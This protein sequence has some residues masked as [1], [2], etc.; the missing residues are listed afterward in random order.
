MKKIS[1]CLDMYGCP[2]KCKH[3]WLGVTP[4]G[5][6]TF[7]DLKFVANVFRPFTKNLEVFDRYRE[8]DYPNNYKELWDL[9]TELSDSKT[10]HFENISYWRVVRDS[11]YA[12]WLYSIGVR[13]A[14][15][16]VFGDQ[17]TTDDFIGRKGAFKE[18]LQAID[19]LLQSKIAPRVQMF[20]YKSNIP[21]L[22]YVQQLIETL[23]LEKRCGDIGNEFGFFLHQGSCSGENEQFYDVWI[24][25]DD[26]EKIPSKL[27]EL[28]I[29][30]FSKSSIFEVLGE[31]E[32]DLYSQL[33]H[34]PSTSSIVSECP[35]FFVDRAFNV[36]P[37]YDTPSPF[38]CLGNLKSD[39]AE[40]ILNTYANSKS[41]AQ[42][43]LATVPI[44]EMVLKHGDI[45][46]KRLFKKQ[47]YRNFMLTKYCRLL[48]S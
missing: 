4:N 26:V 6:L 27:V 37:N 11:E 41:I 44:S 2:N 28:T 42:H 20:I 13:A 21:Q 43:C 34:D 22:K 3:C 48:S 38:W 19:I 31:P 16:T 45:N 18:I 46:S 14:Q 23:G 8:E 33:I 17:E 5:N 29:K 25:P 32:H 36:Y 47:D 7:D 24:T 39:G 12:P 40:K 1:V 10:P 15:L 9:T 30:H 35:V